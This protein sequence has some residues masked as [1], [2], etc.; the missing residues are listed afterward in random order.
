[1]KYFA[2]S[3]C[4][5]VTTLVFAQKSVYQSDSFENLSKDHKVL[6]ILPFAVRLDLESQ[7]EV[8]ESQLK[9]LEKQ[10]GYAVQSALESYFLKRD[11]RKDY[12]VE[13]QNVKNTNALLLKAGINLENIDVKTT[14]ELSEILGVDGVITGDVSLNALISE[15]VDDSFS[16]ID[17]IS[18]K[19]DYGRI[20]IKL[21]D[22]ATGKLLWRF[23]QTIDRKSG[24]NT[25]AII[26]KM[27]RTSTRK[28]PYDKSK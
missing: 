23:E 5:L 11:K 19:S 18:G 27:M 26:E 16:F 2:L 24:K 17:Y 6:A 14:Q 13:F 28:F 25:N 21:S 8:S 12:R 20:A 10:E 9:D 1:M 7:G 4:M 3:V 15:G 22:G